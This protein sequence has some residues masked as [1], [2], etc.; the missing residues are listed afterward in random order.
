MHVGISQPLVPDKLINYPQLFVYQYE[1]LCPFRFN[2]KGGRKPFQIQIVLIRPFK[3]L[4][5]IIKILNSIQNIV[6]TYLLLALA[7]C[8]V[9]TNRLALN[10]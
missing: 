10:L 3:C 9:R 1:V 5:I 4:Y 7:F 2:C 6:L 8:D